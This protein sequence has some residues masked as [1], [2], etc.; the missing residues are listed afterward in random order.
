MQMRLM[1]ILQ[2]K[3]FLETILK[4]AGESLPGDI[5]SSKSRT[6]LTRA[7]QKQH[8]SHPTGLEVSKRLA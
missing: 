7:S 6:P 5:T 4:G 1:V 8:F 2:N 3:S